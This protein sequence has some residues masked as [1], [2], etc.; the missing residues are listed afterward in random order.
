M[1]K[2]K[3]PPKPRKLKVFRTAAGFHDAYVAAPSRAAA[4]RAWGASKDLFARGAAEEVTDPE[5]MADALARPGEV[6]TR[7][8]GGLTEQV[9]A[10]GSVMKPKRP[11][12]ST[13]RKS[14]RAPA[15]PAPPPKPRPDRDDLDAIETALAQLEADRGKAEGELR[16]RERSLDEDRRKLRKDFSER[17]DRLERKAARAREAYEAALR[18]WRG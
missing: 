17:L 12:R 3:S 1:P 15:P 7:S 5:L 4:L 2:A 8:R 11:A 10:L 16:A 6:V 13:A 14:P 9:A 18:E